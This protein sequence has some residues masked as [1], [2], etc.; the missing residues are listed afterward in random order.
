MVEEKNLDYFSGMAIHDRTAK[1]IIPY[2]HDYFI[3]HNP[4]A[5]CYHDEEEHCLYVVDREHL[6][7][8]VNIPLE[9]V[10]PI[11]PPK[12]LT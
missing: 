3:Q 6:V 5:M 11:V 8:I 2:Y 10:P 4:D 1:P 9:K 12:N 7:G